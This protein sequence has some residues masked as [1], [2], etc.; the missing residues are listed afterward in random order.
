VAGSA[1]SWSF[2]RHE[3]R[4]PI[5]GIAVQRPHERFGPSPGWLDV[6]I[7]VAASPFQGSLRTAWFFEDLDQLARTFAELGCRAAGAPLI[8]GGNR[9]AEL[10]LS[11]E[12]VEA[13]D[14]TADELVVE[15]W[16]TENGDDPTPALSFL[17]YTT[18]AELRDAADSLIDFLRPLQ[19]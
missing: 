18:R 12:P 15:A 17:F 2:D 4:A 1:W 13:A 10:H 16:L 6:T 5:I 3:A 9:A 14:A 11:A 19:S 8:V 7:D